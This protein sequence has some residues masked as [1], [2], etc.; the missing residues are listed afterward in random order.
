MPSANFNKAVKAADKLRKKWAAGG[1]PASQLFDLASRNDVL[2]FRL[3]LDHRLSGAFI[4]SKRHKAGIIVINMTEKSLVHQRFTL[5]HELG[6]RELHTDE[7]AIIDVTGENGSD[8]RHKEAN[9]FAAQLLVPKNEL[10]N[11]L[12][13]YKV[14][15]KLVTDRLVVELAQAFG[16]SHE[17]ILWRLKVVG[18]LSQSDVETRIR[19]TDWPLVW[20]RHAPTAYRSIVS[21]FKPD[22]WTPD[23]VSPETAQQVSRLPTHYREMAFEAYQRRVITAGKLADVLGLPSKEQVLKEI[24]PLIDSDQSRADQKLANALRSLS[25]IEGD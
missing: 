18:H 20:Q 22:G 17:V 16:V 6:H 8:P 2:V 12:Q 21:K 25:E 15:A 23:G 9:V 19:T 14:S 5:A 4:R 13:S 7:D 10:E 11:E 24:V 1:R 3:E